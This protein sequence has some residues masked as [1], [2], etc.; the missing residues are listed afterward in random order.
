MLWACSLTPEIKFRKNIYRA[1]FSFTPVLNENTCVVLYLRK[2][3]GTYLSSKPLQSREKLWNY[4]GS[5]MF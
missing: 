5:A 2:N 4:L 1:H 3:L